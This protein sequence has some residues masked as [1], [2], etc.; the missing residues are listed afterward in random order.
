VLSTPASQREVSGRSGNQHRFKLLEGIILFL[1]VPFLLFPQVFLP[2]TLTVL[3]L[4]AVIWLLPLL[5][6]PRQPNLPPTPFNIVLIFWCLA[7]SIGILVT[8]DP[9]ETLPKATGLILG[10]AVWR[11]MAI[12]VKTRRLV[13]IA[14]MV[15]LLVAIGF[16][17]IGMVALDEIVKI[18]VLVSL[19]PA[20]AL[21][22]PVLEG[23]AIHPNQ[24]AGLLSLYLPLLFSL[25]FGGWKH[26]WPRGL[27][28]VLV[29]ST[30]FALTMLVF[31]QSRGGWIGF[32]A[33]LGALV[34]L[35]GIMLPPSRGRTLLRGSSLVVGLVIV[36]GILMIGPNNIESLWLDPPAETVVGT[37]ET[38]NF[39]R[40]LW[41]WAV[42]AIGDFPF[43]GTGLGSFRHVAFRLYPLSID[44]RYDISHAHNIFLQTALDVGVPGLINYLALL[45]LAAGVGWQVAR[46]N[47]TF[48][49]VALGVL[50]GLVAFHVY[51]QADAIALGA[52][53]GLILWMFFGL[54]T[55]M[56]QAIMPV[57]SQTEN[58]IDH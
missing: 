1:A 27:R 4:L 24:L 25:L 8:A 53:P 43:T 42:T 11:Y 56:N 37:L 41:P 55:A 54:L 45:L 6:R 20:R 36:V 5:I 10:L 46:R 38:L 44:P 18:P 17:L 12:V 3:I 51:G 34:A 14:T 15:T 16:S 52:K 29:I 35:W 49:P 47:S 21:S 23:L 31:T 32:I 7:L 48:R 30:L 58:A 19:N 22:T 28:V 33:G 50:A 9:A 13:L 40:E 57:T 2:I 26:G 39:R